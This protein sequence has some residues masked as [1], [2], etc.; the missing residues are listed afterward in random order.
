MHKNTGHFHVTE[1]Q[2][3]QDPD[4][5]IYLSIFKYVFLKVIFEK[6]LKVSAQTK[7]NGIIQFLSWSSLDR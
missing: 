3:I 1:N 2:K 5:S 7:P 6:L 4:L